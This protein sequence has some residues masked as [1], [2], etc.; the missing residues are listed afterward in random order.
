MRKVVALP[1][2]FLAPLVLAGTK[3]QIESSPRDRIIAIDGSRVGWEE[4]L[5]FIENAGLSI[6]F[7]NDNEYL[8]VC[9]HSKNPN[10]TRQAMMHGLHLWLGPKEAKKAFGIHYPVGVAGERPEPRPRGERPD[11]EEMRERMEESLDT[12]RIMGIDVE[13]PQPVPRVNELGIEVGLDMDRGELLYEAKIP[14]ESSDL[15]PY[16]IGAAP[17]DTIRVALETPEIDRDEMRERMGPMGGGRGGMGGGR[18][19]MGGGRGGMGGGR[20]GMGGGMGPMG[21]RRPE[22]PEPVKVKMKVILAAAE[23]ET[24]K[25]D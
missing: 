2:L 9:V 13:Q 21:G 4:R 6:G 11:P 24:G 16:A 25:E 17:G 23:P 22:M 7:T 19:G 12:F 5:T 3:N 15:H 1:L 8:Y 10:V 14:L 20:G 18:G